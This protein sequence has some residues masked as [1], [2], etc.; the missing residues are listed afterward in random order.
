MM[1][2]RRG[3]QKNLTTKWTL[4]ANARFFIPFSRQA[5]SDKKVSKIDER[6]V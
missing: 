2:E 4:N 3:E 1:Y 6:N 5:K